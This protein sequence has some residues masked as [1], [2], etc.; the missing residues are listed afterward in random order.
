MFG[1]NRKSKR[2]EMMIEPGTGGNDERGTINE[3]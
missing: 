1:A 3:I 2:L